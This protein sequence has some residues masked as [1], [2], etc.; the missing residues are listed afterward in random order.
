MKA[1]IKGGLQRACGFGQS[2]LLDGSESR[3]FAFAAAN[4]QTLLYH[5]NCTS[6]EDPD[7]RVCANHLSTGMYSKIDRVYEVSF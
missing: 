2:L 6:L 4:R 1:T 7:N 5:W 3:D